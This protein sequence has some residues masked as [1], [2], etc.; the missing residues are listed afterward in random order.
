LISS[1]L[2]TSVIAQSNEWFAEASNL[3]NP[4]PPIPGNGRIV[5]TGGWYDG[6]ETRR[7]NKLAF[8]YVIIALGPE[9]SRNGGGFV[10]GV[11]IDTAFFNGNEAPAI[12]VEGFCPESPP[13]SEEAQKTLNDETV[14]WGN[15]KG[16][17][18]TILSKQPCGPTRRQAWLLETPTAKPYTHIRLNMYPDGGIARFRLY[19]R[20]KPPSTSQQFSDVM[21]LAAVVNGGRYVD[22]SDE[23][24]STC[25]N[26]LLPGRGTDM[27]D[28]WE[29]RR[30]RAEGH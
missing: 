21:D 12:S 16:K 22:C 19:G 4:K 18:E 10:H 3:I 24:F 27:G 7:H 23:H 26:L 2:S 6:W 30:S 9:L 13:A 11:E 28:G 8:D 20:P 25:S 14:K 17:W 1:R 5:F 15:E 29:T